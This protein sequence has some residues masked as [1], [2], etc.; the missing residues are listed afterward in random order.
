MVLGAS[1]DAVQGLMGGSG[2]DDF[3]GVRLALATTAAGA[4]GGVSQPQV[5]LPDVL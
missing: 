2:E 3:L 1:V 5:T 4:G